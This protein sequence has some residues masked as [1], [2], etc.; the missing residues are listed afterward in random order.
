MV[1]RLALVSLV[2]AG[3]ASVA[4]ANG[5]PAATSTITF[6]R[7][8]EQHIVAGMTFGMVTSH[9]D[10]ATWHW[11]CEKALK[12][13]GN[14]DPD[15]GYTASGALFATTFDGSLVNRDGCSFDASALGNKFISSLT[16][17]PGGEV[18][19]AASH[20]ATPAMND[21]GDAKIYK[22]TDD[23]MTFPAS[24]N[25][26]QVGDWWTSVEVAPSDPQRVYLTGFRLVSAVRTHLVF[27]STDGG[28]SFQPM[29]LT[30]ITL[31]KDSD[32][33]IVGIGKTDPNKVYV[34]VTYQTVGA[35]SD[36]IYRTT[37]GGDSW[38]L[39]KTENDT[40]TFLVRH[41]GDLLVA[42]TNVGLFSS[43]A[44]SNGSAW[45]PITGAPT[46]NCLAEN[47][48]NEVW[49]C[50][51]NLGVEAA[52]IMKTT[53][54]A[55]WTKV[56]EYKDISGPVDCPAGTLQQ[57]KCVAEELPGV[58]STEWCCLKQMLGIVAD[59]TSC[60]VVPA[61]DGAPPDGTST[62]KPPD[63]TCCSGTPGP[64]GLLVGLGVG[65]LLL[66]PRR[67]AA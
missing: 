46:I 48:A 65:L 67:R 61:G 8:M 9:D 24:A 22:S 5:R 39:I 25:P 66:R 44:A 38:E 35:V 15:Y 42:G 40:L 60:A 21:P 58:C 19:M 43:T 28:A 23:G 30:G 50:T 4:W 3:T 20:V 10:G 49:A 56:L 41:N 2:V 52:G 57:D 64:G 11:M 13:G 45:T 59:P 26:G 17:G 36:G 37:N 29:N 31:T 12:Y 63:T 32:I 34:R 51:Q 18:F 1:R 33:S 27:R 6:R 55:A 54:L 62:I 47:S 7:G 14:W 53:D 16:L